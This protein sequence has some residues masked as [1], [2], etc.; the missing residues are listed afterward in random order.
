MNMGNMARDGGHFFLT[1][2]EKDDILKADSSLAKWIHPLV[3][4][5]EF[6]KGKKRWCFWFEGISPAEIAK[7]RI[8][9][10]IVQAVRDFRLASNAK[11]TRGYAKTPHLWAQVCQ[12]KTNF[13]VVPVVSSERRVYIPMGFLAPDN[14]PTTQVQ[15]IPHAATVVVIW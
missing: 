6:I 11:T 9:Y 15:I 3:G 5:E 8:I 13:I 2:E 7:N 12:P 1:E 10:D 4:A 14:I